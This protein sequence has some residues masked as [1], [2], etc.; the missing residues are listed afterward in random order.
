VEASFFTGGLFTGNGSALTSLNPSALS[1]NIPASKF[2]LNTV[3]LNALQQFGNIDVINGNATIGGTVTACNVVIASN[4]TVPKGTFETLGLFD[5][6][7]NAYQNITF[8][9]LHFMSVS[10]AITVTP[11]ELISTAAGINSNVIGSITLQNL[12]SS[13]AGLGTAGY[14]SSSQLTSSIAGIG[15]LGTPSLVSTVAGLGTAGYISSS[16]LISSIA[17]IGALGTPSLVSTV[18]GL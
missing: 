13:I 11:W 17:G 1:G 4:L 12:V 3:P 10:Q 7:F 5:T 14:V 2:G 6:G 18:A 8:S 16:Q 15:A 9:S